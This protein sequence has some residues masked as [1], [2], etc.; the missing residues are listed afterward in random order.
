MDSAQVMR[1]CGDGTFSIYATIEGG[2]LT[3]GATIPFERTIGA[4]A[5]LND[6][7]I[8]VDDAHTGDW[9]G[10]AIHEAFEIH[11]FIAAPIHVNGVPWGVLSFSSKAARRASLRD[12]DMDFVQLMAAKIGV[13]LEREMR[14]EELS[15]MAF[16]DS[17]T[18]LPNRTLFLEHASK[19]LSRSRRDGSLVAFHYLDLDGFK[20]VNDRYGHSTGDEL[21]REVARRLG[22]VIRDSDIV[23]RLAGD[24]FVYVQNGVLSAHDALALARRVTDVLNRPYRLSGCELQISASI[25]ISMSPADGDDVETLLKRADSALYQVKSHGKNGAEL[26][27][28]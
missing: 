19:A 24:E 6:Q 21:L 25:G 26:F 9:Q 15:A 13:S 20:A 23:A 8:A 17:L 27:T 16:Y 22:G 18:A 14:Q 5:L 3:T 10:H 1:D 2:S 12:T 7:P 11:A 4:R 28:A